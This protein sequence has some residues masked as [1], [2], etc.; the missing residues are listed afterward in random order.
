MKNIKT[1][2]ITSFLI[3]TFL[4]LSGLTQ[5]AHASFQFGEITARGRGCPEGTTQVVKSP[6]QKA[7]SILFDQFMAEVPQFDNDND[8]DEVTGENPRRRRRDD[9]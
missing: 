8:N 3:F 7:M 1:Q 4:G 2:L 6:D 5:K 9:E